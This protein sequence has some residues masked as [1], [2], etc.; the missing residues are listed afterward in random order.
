VKASNLSHIS[1]DGVPPFSPCLFI[2]HQ[3]RPLH[4]LTNCKPNHPEAEFGQKMLVQTFQITNQ[5]AFYPFEA[6]FHTFGLAQQGMLASVL[7]LAILHFFDFFNKLSRR[8]HT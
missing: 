7:Y 6:I 2:L 5:P 3:N 1:D 4:A 8:L